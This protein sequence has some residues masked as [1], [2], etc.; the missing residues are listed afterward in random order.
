ML[1]KVQW[2]WQNWHQNS[3][4]LLLLVRYRLKKPETLERAIG[5]CGQN[6]NL[7][8]ANARHQNKP[9]GCYVKTQGLKEWSQDHKC[10]IEVEDGI[11]A[12]WKISAFPDILRGAL[13]L[14]RDS[15]FAKLT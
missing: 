10:R 12:L 8:Q 5:Q 9:E 1:W 14:S 11:E 2:K 13:I 6:A 15:A 7:T 4:L 3:N